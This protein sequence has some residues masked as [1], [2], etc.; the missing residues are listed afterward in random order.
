[1]KTGGDYTLSVLRYAAIVAAFVCLGAAAPECWMHANAMASPAAAKSPSPQ[2]IVAKPGA[3]KPAK[4]QDQPQG[5]TRVQVNVVRLYA[6]VRDKHNAIITNLSK[7]DFRVFEDGQQQQIAIFSKDMTDPITL[8][9]MIDTS[10]SQQGLLSAEQ[11]TGSEFLQQI[12]KKDDLAMVLSFD[13]NVNLLADFSDNQETLQ[14]AIQRAEI[15]AAINAGPVPQANQAGTVLYDAIYQTCRNALSQQ[16]GRKAMI[17]LT[18]AEDEGSTHTL[19][20][21]I[22]AAQEANAVVHVLLIVNRGFYFQQGAMYGGASAASKLAKETGGRVISIRGAKDL[23]KAFQEI[24]EELRNQYVIGYYPTN[25][26]DDGSFRKVKVE[27][28]T[29]GQKVLTR[30]G[31]YAPTAPAPAQ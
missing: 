2:I 9:M 20:D 27:T 6:T 5:V 22:Q 16:A 21:A 26:T 10:P 4:G 14:K 17:I 12:L 19:D 31:H 30:E 13:S 28:T 18:D 29:S 23:D 3:V 1:M 8:A 7:D 15:N 11:E 24:S 25:K